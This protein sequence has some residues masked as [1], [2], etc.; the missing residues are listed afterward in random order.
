MAPGFVNK[1]KYVFYPP[2]CSHEGEHKTAKIIRQN[3]MMEK[4]ENK[5]LK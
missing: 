1:L 2:G 3:Y 5:Y 4:K